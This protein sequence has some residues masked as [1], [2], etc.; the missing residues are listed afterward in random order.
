MGVNKQWLYS[1]VITLENKLKYIERLSRHGITTDAPI[2]AARKALGN[3]CQ[4][5]VAADDYKVVSRVS[6]VVAQSLGSSGVGNAQFPVLTNVYP[7]ELGRADLPTDSGEWL[8]NW[9]PGKTL[10]VHGVAMMGRADWIQMAPLVM[11]AKKYGGFDKVILEMPSSLLPLMDGK[12][13]A[14]ELVAKDSPL[15]PHDYHVSL[16][17]LPAW[18][19]INLHEAKVKNAY[20]APSEPMNEGQA[21]WVRSHIL[22][23]KSEGRD[24]YAFAL[25]ARKGACEEVVSLKQLSPLFGMLAQKADFVCLRS[26]AELERIGLAQE[27][28]ALSRDGQKNILALP[29]YFNSD[30]SLSGTLHVVKAVNAVITGDT[31][32]LHAAAAAGGKVIGLLPY[33]PDMR[34][35]SLSAAAQAESGARVQPYAYYPEVTLVQQP[36]PKAW[37]PV[38]RETSRRL[39]AHGL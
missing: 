23:P 15:P 16:M 20:L 27:F 4:E 18:M 28:S 6:N 19:G 8:G 11:E 7:K 24:V 26:E 14:D 25:K 22:D 34:Y 31:A 35:P 30:E 13:L 2:E 17:N 5:S 3:I 9:M 38:L 29:P 33:T 1:Q 12:K 39:M 21:A 36:K 32:L 10:L 37:E